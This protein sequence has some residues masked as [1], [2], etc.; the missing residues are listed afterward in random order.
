M[1]SSDAKTVKILPDDWQIAKV[2]SVLSGTFIYAWI[3]QAI[4]E[5]AEREKQERENEKAKQ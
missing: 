2:Q 1:S 5:K 4:R 3:G